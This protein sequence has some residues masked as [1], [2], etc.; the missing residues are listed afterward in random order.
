MLAN[1][2]RPRFALSVVYIISCTVPTVL[3]EPNKENNWIDQ[4]AKKG[5]E[6]LQSASKFT[7]GDEDLTAKASVMINDY[8]ASGAPGKI[9]YGFLMGY[10][11]GFF[12][13]KA[14]RFVAFAVGGVFALVQA[15]A[16]NGYVIVN[17]DKMKTDVERMMDQNNDGVIDSKDFRILFDKVML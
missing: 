15:L 12:V 13:K 5:K 11:S 4:F 17:H 14:S 7:E 9:S 16:Y 1:L 8:F 2:V 3:C 6:A 10:S